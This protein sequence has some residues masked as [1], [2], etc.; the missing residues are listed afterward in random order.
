M[1][2]VHTPVLLIRLFIGETN[3]TSNIY[4]TTRLFRN[5][6]SSVEDDGV[7][8]NQISCEIAPVESRSRR[9]RLSTRDWFSF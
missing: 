6:P 5:V 8:A 9:T 7:R 4:N 3:K 1:V 2:F